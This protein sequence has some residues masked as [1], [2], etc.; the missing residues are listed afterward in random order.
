M[1][2]EIGSATVM[3][4]DGKPVVTSAD[5]VICVTDELLADMPAEADGSYLLAGDPNYRYRVVGPSRHWPNVTVMRRAGAGEGV[6]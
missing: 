2:D 4:V 5:D 1:S 3:L 6:G